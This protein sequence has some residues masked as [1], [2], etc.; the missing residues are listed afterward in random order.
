MDQRQALYGPEIS[1]PNGYPAMEYRD[2]DRYPARREPQPPANQGEHPYAAFSAAG[3]GDDGYR[4]PGYDGPASQDAG[5]AEIG[6]AH[7]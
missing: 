6:R 2:G 4:D 1:W 7:V 3:Y 5:I